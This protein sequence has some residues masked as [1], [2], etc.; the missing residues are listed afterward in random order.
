MRK[1]SL[2]IMVLTLV[3]VVALLFSACAKP[4]PAPAPTTP[5]PTPT[6]SAKPEP[7][8]PITL[9][10]SYSMPL[11]RGPCHGWHWWAEEIDKRTNGQVKVEIY[12]NNTLYQISAAL[13]SVKKGVAD[14]SMISPGVD[15]RR[16]PLT[17]VTQLPMLGFPDDYEGNLASC[18]AVSKLID[19]FPEVAAEWKDIKML[20]PQQMG[21]YMLCCKK[22]VRVPNDLKGQKIGG[23]GQKMD[24]ITAIGGV[25]VDMAPPATYEGL[26][27]N[28]VD[29]TFNSWSQVKSYTM[30]DVADYFLNLGISQSSVPVVFNVNSFNS[31]PADV[32]KLMYDLVPEALSVSVKGFMINIDEGRALAK[33]KGKTIVN[34]TKD[35]IELWEKGAE[36]MW[37]KWVTDNEAKGTKNARQILDEWKRLRAEA[38]K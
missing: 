2:S 35:E 22:E 26:Q 4:E 25:R 7:A 17:N 27:K 21:N 18:Y 28:V 3:L 20:F 37:D 36:P 30:T 24:F 6:P 13:D 9:K 1:M 5:S 15:F 10:F 38:M 33:S 11:R 14:I 31:L 19:K 29:A 8:K 34:P 23:T 16:M 12:P 32:Q